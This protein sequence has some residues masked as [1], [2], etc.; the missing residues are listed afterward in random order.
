MNTKA[1]K[2]VDD[3]TIDTANLAEYLGTS[4][5]SIAQYV[6]DG[7]LSPDKMDGNRPKFLI[8][9]LADHKQDV[10]NMREARKNTKSVAGLR[11]RVEALET[12]VNELQKFAQTQRERIE[13]VQG[14]VNYLR[15]DVDRLTGKD[16][17]F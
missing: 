17:P 6:R 10:E 7:V 11:Q 15:E 1:P 5:H 14:T 8:S 9:R 13:S 2:T 16:V 4:R 3:L 12:Y